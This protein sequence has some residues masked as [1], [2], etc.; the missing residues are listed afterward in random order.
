M[1]GPPNRIGQQAAI[2]RVREAGGDRVAVYDLENEAGR[3]IYVHAKVCVIDDVWAA[4]GSDNL[5]RRSWT[6]DS[7]LSCAVIDPAPDDREPADPGGQGDGARAFARNL[8]LDLWREHLGPHIPDRAL[9][10]PVE[11]FLTWH[12]AAEVLDDWHA[13]GRKGSR[14]QGRVR[15]HRPQTVGPMAA[16]WAAPAYR[17]L[18]DPD[19]RPAE[20]KRAGRF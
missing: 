8:R 4:V 3:P 9:L 19:G 18:V 7:E 12:H 1:S 5:N 11:G 20:L 17:L 15:R 6:H 2:R 14:P 10:D 16:W 13:G